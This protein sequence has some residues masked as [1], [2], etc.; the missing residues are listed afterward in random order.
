MKK[1]KKDFSAFQKGIE[2]MET[3]MRGIPDRVPVFAQ[4]HEFAMKELGANAKEFFTTSKYLPAAYLAILEKYGLDVPYIDYD[5]YNIEAEA[6]GQKIIYS[7]HDMPDIDRLD[8]LIK[9]RADLKKIKTPDFTSDGR[10]ATVVEINNIFCELVGT[11]PT[12]NFCAPFTLAANIRGI[13][14]L[15]MDIMMDP[16][17]AK[18]LFDRLT[19]ELLAPWIIYLKERFPAAKSICGSDAMASLPIINMEILREWIVPYVLRLQQICGAEVYVPNWVGEHYL[20]NPE[21][22]FEFKLQACPNFL[23]GQDPD[24]ESIGPGVYKKYADKKRVPL[25][26]GV[27]ASFLALSTPEEI[28]E[29]V[30]HY[31]EVGGKNGRLCLYLCNIGATTPSENLKAAVDA[32]HK[33]GSYR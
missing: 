19:E 1:F 26:L 4:M 2:R 10:F 11:E 28:T 27:G 17:F 24:V 9:S 31:I 3:A 15:L 32:V 7:E 22:M 29:R 6:I 18:E 33:Y 13:E 14:Q 8:P 21:E 20:R 16:D 25:I 30:K 5:M 23:E 12:L